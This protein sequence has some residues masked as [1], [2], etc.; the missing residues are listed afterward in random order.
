MTENIIENDEEHKNKS[1][2]LPLNHLKYLF[3]DD[4]PNNILE[5]LKLDNISNYSITPAEYAIQITEKI[6]IITKD[7]LKKDISKLVITEM[8]A[9]VGGNIISFAKNF[10]F[11]NAIELCVERYNFLTHNLRVLELDKNVQCICGD[12][13]IEIANTKQINQ[14]IIF[15]DSAWG[16]PKYKYK[17]V[18]NLYI[19]KLPLYEACNL[20]KN[21]CKIQV[22]KVPNNFNFEKFK[23]NISLNVYEIVKL[24]K[25]KL[26]ILI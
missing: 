26:I 3:G 13:L 11:V 18:V 23:E 8:T 12:S 7:I 19:S 15:W 17:E 10:K 24:G 1:K 9:C 20:V 14:D 16:G 6:R 5:Q 2:H 22:L 4:I 25:F 21:F